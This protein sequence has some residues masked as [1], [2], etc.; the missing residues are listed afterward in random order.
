MIQI[1]NK[2]A[3]MNVHSIAEVDGVGQYFLSYAPYTNVLIASGW[4]I[5]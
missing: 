3:V 1:E 4:M 5:I 2:E